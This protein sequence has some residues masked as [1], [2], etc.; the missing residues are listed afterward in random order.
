MR[1]G[2]AACVLVLVL[3]WMTPSVFGQYPYPYPP[4]GY[5]PMPVQYLQPAFAPH[6][7]MM[8]PAPY[9]PPG[10]QPA[11]P[12]PT[13]F[14]YGP[15]T[16]LEAD[17]PQMTPV[18]SS[19]PPA[20]LP[21]TLPRRENGKSE[22]STGSHGAAA[23]G[24]YP[25]E[26]ASYRKASY[27]SSEGCG[28]L[29]CG[30]F[31]QEYGPCDPVYGK[32]PPAARGHGQ[33]IGEVGA[34]FLVPVTNARPAFTTA[35][36]GGVPD[37]T[38]FPQTVNFGP[39]VSLGYLCHTGWGFRANYW[40][41]RG[42]TNQSVTN[43]DLNTLIATPMAAPFLITSPS[44]TLQQGLGTDQ[45]GFSQRIDINVADAEVL[46][47]CQ[48]MDTTFLWNVGARYARIIQSYAATR[49]NVGGFNGINVVNIDREELNSSSLFEGWGPTV[50]LEFIHRLGSSDC[51]IYG[52]VRGSF[53]FGVERF[54]QDYSAQRHSVDAGVPTFFETATNNF[55]S[56]SRIL[57]IIETELG[58]Q[59]G[60]RFGRCYVFTRAGGVYQ[61]WWDVGSP[62]SPTGSLS[63]LGGTARIGITY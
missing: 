14:V 33:F 30:D 6:P 18:K 47:E 22:K 49:T 13:V 8:P 7:A 11:P 54:T 2:L 59:Y 10:W 29:G 45:L 16:P 27:T 23:A 37:T 53:L 40:Y 24:R 32:P 42:T 44:L 28:P 3:G 63:F 55:A 12:R 61:R 21:P 62:I 26:Q 46:K 60:H 51:S 17:Q 20:H 56:D 58:L 4:P 15:L 50:G 35:I 9:P 31:C 48:F 25:I 5:G 41:L 39:R 57:S 34:Y 52:S 1:R 43:S 38:D 36:G 19:Q